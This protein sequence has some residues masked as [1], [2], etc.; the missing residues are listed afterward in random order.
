[1]S[2]ISGLFIN[3]FN[4][5]KKNK[6]LVVLHSQELYSFYL[7][8]KNHNKGL[9]FSQFCTLFYVF[10]STKQ[11]KNNLNLVLAFL[12]FFKTVPTLK[13]EPVKILNI[14]SNTRIFAF[15][16]VILTAKLNQF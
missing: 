13:V 2:Q 6:S 15:K 11:L 10:I 1:M 16:G 7:V 14:L 5:K 4:S 3:L 9:N 8:F 12:F